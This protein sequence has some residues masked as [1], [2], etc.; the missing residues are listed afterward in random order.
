MIALTD[1]GFGHFDVVLSFVD[2]GHTGVD[3][4]IIV[5]GV[6]GGGLIFI[7]LGLLELYSLLFLGF[8]LLLDEVWNG[9]FTFGVAFIRAMAWFFAEYTPKFLSCLQVCFLCGLVFLSMIPRALLLT[10]TSSQA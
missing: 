6:V 7:V 2:F 10:M 1:R 8:P 4:L 3:R 9:S 5:I